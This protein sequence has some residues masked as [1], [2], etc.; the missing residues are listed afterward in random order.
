VLEARLYAGRGEI[1]MWS[2]RP[3]LALSPGVIVRRWAER[4]KDAS[5]LTVHFTLPVREGS[6][7]ES[8]PGEPRA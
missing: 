7:P 3:R 6:A 1:E 4:N 5:G 2:G 8:D